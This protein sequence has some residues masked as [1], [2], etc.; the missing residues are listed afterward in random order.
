[1]VRE[2][3]PVTD[4]WDATATDMGLTWTNAG[5]Q[6]QAIGPNGQPYTKVPGTQG[7]WKPA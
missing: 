5:G 4:A 7:T 6:W 2:G 1:M 3:A